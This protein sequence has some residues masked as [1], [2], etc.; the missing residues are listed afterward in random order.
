MIIEPLERFLDKWTNW[1]EY[2]DDDIPNRNINTFY[3]RFDLPYYYKNKIPK[4]LTVEIEPDLNIPTYK[5]QILKIMFDLDD[6]CQDIMLNSNIIHPILL[7]Q[8][9]KQTIIQMEKELTSLTMQR[10]EDSKK[11]LKKVTI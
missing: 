9:L 6:E 1:Y 4:P 11:A 7:S 5:K 8:H 10:L 2:C 3:F